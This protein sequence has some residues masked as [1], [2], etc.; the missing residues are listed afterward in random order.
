[1]TKRLLLLPVG[2]TAATGFSSREGD[3]RSLPV[4]V[5]PDSEMGLLP[6]P[7][8][9]LQTE[10]P[11][12]GHQIPTLGSGYGCCQ[13][14]PFPGATPPSPAHSAHS[15]FQN[16]LSANSSAGTVVVAVLRD[17]I[18][19]RWHGARATSLAS[20]V[21]LLYGTFT[22][23]GVRAEHQRDE[24]TELGSERGYD[25]NIW[26]G[27]IYIRIFDHGTSINFCHAKQNIPHNSIRSRRFSVQPLS[28]RNP[29]NPPL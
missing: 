26:H 15:P 1:M 13:S 11:H 16:C 20:A 12:V 9:I 8:T 23:P 3:I 10:Q 18:D 25:G 24:P 2:G 19:L 28:C 4:P 21:N 27:T 5:A 7:P 6:S 14:Y 29:H 17:S 22:T